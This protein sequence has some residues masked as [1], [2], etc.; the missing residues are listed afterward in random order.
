K[1]SEFKDRVARMEKSVSELES[2]YKM[3][4]ARYDEKAIET[5][6]LE[7]ELIKLQAKKRAYEK[8]ISL[9]KSNELALETRSESIKSKALQIDGQLKSNVDVKVSSEVTLKDRIIRVAGKNQKEALALF[10]CAQAIIA[11]I[12]EN[13]FEGVQYRTRVNK[14]SKQIGA[15][16]YF[17]NITT[18]YSDLTQQ[19]GPVVSE[20]GKIF[21]PLG[22]EIQT[23]AL[24]SANGVVS[25]LDV[26]LL[27]KI[28]AR[29]EV[30]QQL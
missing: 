6:R 22:V 26:T 18:Q 15:R 14:N 13:E 20:L 3:Q 21:R 12:E 23:K 11:N 8:H 25:A 7:R 2:N 24:K 30:I 29:K 16:I 1:E 5:E 4:K 28:G 17:Y 19:L 27:M 10:N 9:A